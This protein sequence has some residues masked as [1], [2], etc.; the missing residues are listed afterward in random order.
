MSKRKTPE[1][2]FKRFSENLLLKH[3]EIEDKES[4]NL[5]FKKYMAGAS[6]SKQLK[7]RAWEHISRRRPTKITPEQARRFPKAAKLMRQQRPGD[8]KYIGKVK[9]KTVY[10]RKITIRTGYRYIDKRGRYTSVKR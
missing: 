8:F 1:K 6:Y 4:Y 2:D 7:D 3:P 5:A 10:A 9:G